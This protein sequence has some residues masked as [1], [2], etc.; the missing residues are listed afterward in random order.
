MPPSWH[1]I[2]YELGEWER[3]ILNFYDEGLDADNIKDNTY[4]LLGQHY[5]SKK[6]FNVVYGRKLKDLIN[7]GFIKDDNNTKDTES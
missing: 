7:K 1:L 4:E 5:K 3:V 2:G 6:S